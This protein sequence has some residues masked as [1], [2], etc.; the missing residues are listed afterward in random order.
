MNVHHAKGFTLVELTLVVGI[1]S[2]LATIAIPA[3]QNYIH[4]ARLLEVPVTARPVLESVN[5]YYLETGRFPSNNAEAGLPEPSALAGKLV[6]SVSVDHGAIRVRYESRGDTGEV[7]YYPAINSAFP[8]QLPI[9]IT[10]TRLAVEGLTIVGL[11][12][13]NNA[14]E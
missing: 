11:E 5:A 13:S 10:D 3:Y 7:V 12:E 8:Q 4:E 9:W 6:R 1:I 14:Q 2:V